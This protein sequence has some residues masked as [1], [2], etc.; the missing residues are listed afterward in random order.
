MWLLE[1][2]SGRITADHGSLNTPRALK[3][4][5]RSCVKSLRVRTETTARCEPRRKDGAAIFNC[6]LTPDI[7]KYGCMAPY[8]ATALMENRNQPKEKPTSG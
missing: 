7:R 6:T 1:R 3:A 2:N 5:L 4:L 8:D